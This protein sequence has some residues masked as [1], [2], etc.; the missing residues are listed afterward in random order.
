[1]S[2]ILISTI[3]I[4]VCLILGGIGVGVYVAVFKNRPENKGQSPSTATIVLI[5]STSFL[6]GLLIVAGYFMI[7]GTG[8][9]CE[10]GTKDIEELTK[11][12]ITFD[13]LRQ[14]ANKVPRGINYSTSCEAD[15]TGG[16]CGVKTRTPPK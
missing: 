16:A 12:Q 11:A 13:S 5:M 9:D 3:I 6:L 15:A 1:M 14:K 4:L 10:W 7:K 8:S 2:P